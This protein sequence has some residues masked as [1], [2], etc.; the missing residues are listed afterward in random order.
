[1]GERFST[2]NIR[3]SRGY[4]SGAA[5]L[6]DPATGVAG[7]ADNQIARARTVIPDGAADARGDSTPARGHRHELHRARRDC[8]HVHPQGVH[9]VSRACYNH[10][11]RRFAP[12]LLTVALQQ[13]PLCRI[14]K[15]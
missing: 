15:L 3:Y 8:R 11:H 1:M 6:A 10:S 13:T 4:K 2:R 7:Q 14:R 9:A 12:M 5:M